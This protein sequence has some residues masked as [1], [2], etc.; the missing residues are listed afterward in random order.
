[1]CARHINT[2]IYDGFS[3]LS[4]MLSWSVSNAQTSAHS[5]DFSSLFIHQEILL[6]SDLS[7]QLKTR[8]FSADC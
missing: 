3:H 7:Y 1:M 2:K 5:S 6:F 8:Y 4:W